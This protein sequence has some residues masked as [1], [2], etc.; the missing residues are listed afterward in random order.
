[1]AHYLKTNTLN[2][3]LCF[4]SFS[5]LF[6]SLT[7]NKILF[8]KEWMIPLA[9]LSFLSPSNPN[10][11]LDFFTGGSQAL[12][13][14]RKGQSVSLP[15]YTFYEL[16]AVNGVLVQMLLVLRL[17]FKGDLVQVMPRNH[18]WFATEGIYSARKTGLDVLKRGYD[19]RPHLLFRLLF[20]GAI[21]ECW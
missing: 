14:P 12:T 17:S 11:S 7:C 9:S 19:M 5:S 18:L 15:L 1:M 21:K 16:C 3:N 8:T 20:G 6:Y 10:T 4:Y 13:C 2:I